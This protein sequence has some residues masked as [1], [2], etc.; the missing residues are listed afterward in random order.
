MSDASTRLAM[1]DGIMVY[2]I[3]PSVQHSGYFLLFGWSR[4]VRYCDKETLNSNKQT[5]KLYFLV[6]L[7]PDGTGTRGDL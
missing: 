1:S 6:I 4:Y 2:D 5:N 7:Y 3:R